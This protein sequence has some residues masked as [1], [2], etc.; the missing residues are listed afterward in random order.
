MSGTGMTWEGIAPSPNGARPPALAVLSG[1]RPSTANESADRLVTDA[2]PAGRDESPTNRRLPAGR[3]S[4]PAALRG[5]KLG[6]GP[7]RRMLPLAPK[8]RYPTHQ[9]REA[10]E[11]SARRS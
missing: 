3:L 7:G 6:D 1:H 5:G 10:H 11:R 9:H 4:R 2:W 8:S